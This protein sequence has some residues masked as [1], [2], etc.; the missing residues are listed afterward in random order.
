MPRK[1]IPVPVPPGSKFC[2]RCQTVHPLS[3]FYR[4]RTQP[5]GHTS[6]CSSCCKQADRE[7]REMRK[8]LDEEMAAM[9]K[10][11]AASTFTYEFPVPPMSV[12]YP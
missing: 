9:D 10:R 7:A 1:N 4:N 5:D 6:R 8:F 11:L 12:P 3:S 2:H